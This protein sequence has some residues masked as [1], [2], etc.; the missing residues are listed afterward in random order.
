MTDDP[1]HTRPVRFGVLIYDGCD[2]LDAIGPA[3]AFFA[4]HNVRPYVEPFAPVAVHLVAEQAGGATVR[5]GN[6]V[7]L[8]PDTDYAGCPQLDVLVVAGGS[9]GP[10]DVDAGRHRQSRHEPTLEFIRHQVAGGALPASV[11]TGA[12]LLAGAGLLAGHRANTHWL[13]RDELVSFMAAR[14]EAFELVTD[15]VVDDGDVVTCG[16]V[17]SGIDLAL[18]LIDR[19]FGPRVAR[20]T[21]LGIERE[22]PP[23]AEAALAEAAT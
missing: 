20:A 1:N 14:G 16:G 18:A 8:T 21:A 22:T 6:G 3:N 5:S 13:V 9:G 4:L 12:F 17:S 15:R 11:C 2:E 19:Q 7:I 23:S 10:D